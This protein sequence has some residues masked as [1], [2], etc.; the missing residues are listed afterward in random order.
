MHSSSREARLTPDPEL[1]ARQTPIGPAESS[2][3]RAIETATAA[4]VKRQRAD[5]HWVFELEADATI[6]AEYIILQHFL[7]E[8]NPALEAKIARYLRR[9]QAP[10][11]GWPLFHQGDFNISASV[12][13][14]LALKL[15]GDSPEAEH[16]RRAREAILARGGAGKTNV[17]TR[18]LL[19]LFGIVSWVAVPAMPVEIMLLPPWFPFHLSK[20]SY[21][22]RTTI[23]PL[24][25]LQALKPKALNPRGIGIN[26][27]F[28]E[29]PG[30]VKRPPKAPHQ[31]WRWFLL[32]AAID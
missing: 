24:L 3:E 5:G 13:A 27:L 1:V 31:T 28:L 32:F 4:L 26:E 12:K 10:H 22:A 14:Y 30:T 9:L 18:I 7:G 17:F 11:G 6:S 16:M 23:V 2:L 21:W 29:P 20:I 8:P 25:V 19:A 15:V